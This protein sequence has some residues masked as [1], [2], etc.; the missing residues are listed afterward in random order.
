M[1]DPIEA[2]RRGMD[3]LTRANLSRRGLLRAGTFGGVALAGV[4]LVGCDFAPESSVQSQVV[5]G[6][7]PTHPTKPGGARHI[8]FTPDHL[9]GGAWP[10]STMPAGLG[11]NLHF[12]NTAQ[13]LSQIGQLAALGPRFARL[14]FTWSAVEHRRG[15]YNFAGYDPIIQALTSRG[16]R[17]LCILGYNN[18]L[19]ESVPFAPSTAVGPHTDAVRQAYARFAG[20]AAAHFK[21]RNIVWE[22]WNEPDNVRFWAP[23]PSPSGYMALLREAVPALRRADPQALLVAPALTGMSSQYPA[24]WTYLEQCFALGLA[25]LVDAISVHPYRRDS[26]ES[27]IADYQR[28]RSLIARYAPKAKASMPIINS[29]WGY[30]NTWVS[31]DQQAAYLVRLSLINMLSGL[32]ISILYDW[33]DDGR[34][35]KQQEDNFGLLTWQGRQKPAYA[36]IRT[37]VRELGGFRF[38]RRLTGGADYSLLFTRGTVAKQVIWTTGNAHPVTLSVNAGSVTVTSMTGGSRTQPVIAGKTVLEINGDPQYITPG[39]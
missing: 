27:V 31:L 9:A 16:I 6:P 36:A 7:T 13:A 28:L 14:D 33:M 2:S 26:P 21:G 3:G 24:A 30:S 11:V 34:D 12:T 37:L 20:A 15:Q 23:A 32:P 29:E 19:Y 18:S 8:Q 10:A 4:A 1:H 39:A 25:G 35:A 38:N 5:I 22:I 17:P